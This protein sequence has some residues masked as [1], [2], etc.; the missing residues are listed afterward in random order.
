MLIALK[1]Y[2]LSFLV[3]ALILYNMDN[4]PSLKIKC[5]NARGYLSAIPCIR[6][7]LTECDILAIRRQLL[8]ILV[9]GSADQSGTDPMGK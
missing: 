3:F 6:Q 4:S 2:I 9:P 8:D 7:L 5:W 1:I